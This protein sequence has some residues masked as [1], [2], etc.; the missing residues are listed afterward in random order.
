MVISMIFCFP[1][2]KWHSN[3]SVTPAFFGLYN[4][5]DFVKI[6]MPKKLRKYLHRPGS[7]P[8]A[9]GQARPGRL[10]GERV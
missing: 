5:C 9:I 1:Y 2:L 8:F 7:K 3:A 4:K 6:L 10:S